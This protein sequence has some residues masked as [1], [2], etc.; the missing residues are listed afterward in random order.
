MNLSKPMPG[1]A[2]NVQAAGR[3]SDI[4]GGKGRHVG[5][6]TV[7]RAEME[8]PQEN[9]KVRER[10]DR[11]LLT[12]SFEGIQYLHAERGEIPFIPRCPRQVVNSCGCGDHCVFEQIV[13]PAAH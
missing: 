10:P 12:M 1:D 13:P 9:M 5:R 7:Y 2:R 6:T 8:E 4:N 3:R 11:S